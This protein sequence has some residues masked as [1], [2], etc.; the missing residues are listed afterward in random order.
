MKIQKLTLAV[1]LLIFLNVSCTKSDVDVQPENQQSKNKKS[2]TNTFVCGSFINGQHGSSGYYNYGNYAIDLTNYPV[3]TV[4]TVS[5]QAIEVP[6][7]FNV[8]SSGGAGALLSTNWIG[9]SSNW[10]PWGSS[11]N[12]P[13][14]ATLTFTKQSSS[15]NYYN[16][17]VETVVQGYTSDAWEASISCR[18]P[19][20][21]ICP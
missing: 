8:Q 4:V 13:G 14:A 19:N 20:G 5:C 9:W 17:S 7:R 21:T 15:D 16:F 18:H 11:L 1:L 12:G 2:R 3:G 10:G 6:N